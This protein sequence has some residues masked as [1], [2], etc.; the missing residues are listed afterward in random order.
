MGLPF[1]DENMKYDFSKQQ[2]ILTKDCVL[3]NLYL[4]EQIEVFLQTSNKVHQFLEEISD[5]VYLFIYRYT[6]KD[7]RSIRKYLLAKREDYR[8]VIKRAMLYQARYALRSGAIAL[9]DM[10][11]VDIEKTRALG[12]ES[13]RGDVMIAEHARQVL[14]DAGLLYT[15]NLRVRIKDL[16][17]GT[18]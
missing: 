12:L 14:L 6:R 5:D 4:N 13:I 1:N 18:Y 9:K 16:E 15:G 17:D 11:G 2:Y 7:M 10:H 3:N 8:E